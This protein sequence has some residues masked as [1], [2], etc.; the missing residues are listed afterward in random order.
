MSRAETHPDHPDRRLR[1]RS[2][3]IPFERVWTAALLVAEDEI[4]GWSVLRWDD[5]AGIVFVEAHVPILR[6]TDDVRIH[7]SLD[8]NAQTR[9]DVESVAR[10]G[11]LDLGRN[12]R[13]IGRFLALLDQAT[14]AQG[15]QILP[16]E[17]AR[18]VV[19]GRAPAA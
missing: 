3:A 12:A 1:G 16:R 2:Y 19:D 18:S 8:V 4:A 9:V 17:Y 15:S 14:E 5:R 10:Q 13:R 7:I 6:R 11:K